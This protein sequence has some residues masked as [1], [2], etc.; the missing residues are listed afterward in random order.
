MSDR[1]TQGGGFMDI[2]RREFLKFSA[3]AA[4]VGG[5]LD[6]TFDPAKALAYESHPG[7]YQI[8]PTTCPYCSASCGQRVVV[9]PTGDSGQVIDI[10]GDFESPF[11]SGGLC[12]KGAGS[13][14]LVTNPRRIGAWPGSHPVDDVFA[15]ASGASYVTSGVAYRSYGTS[16]GTNTAWERVTL[17]AALDDIAD[18]MITARNAHRIPTAANGYNSKGVAFLGCSHMNN[19][20]NYLYRKII[21]N[22]GTSN[23]E[24]QAR[25]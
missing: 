22:F 6:F 16:G 24:H 18:K 17:E 4:A 1:D 19:E 13:F 7:T 11:N 15:Y 2:S 23:V 9:S 3:T 8:T 14:Q 5:A 21:A 25:I 12:A 10:Y 20:G